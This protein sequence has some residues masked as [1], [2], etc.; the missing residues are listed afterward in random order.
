M[1]A[2]STIASGG[3]RIWVPTRLG[4]RCRKRGPQRLRHLV[5]ETDLN[6]AGSHHRWRDTPVSAVTMSAVIILK[7]PE[8]MAVRGRNAGPRGLRCPTA[9]PGPWVR[10]A[11]CSDGIGCG[12]SSCS[13]GRFSGGKFLEQSWFVERVSLMPT[14]IGGDSVHGAGVLHADI[15]LRELGAAD[16][17]G[18]GAAFGAVT[19]VGPW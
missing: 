7:D 17:S 18:A 19:Q 13:C 15:L 6:R 3:T 14:L 1:S 16:L 8:P 2:T 10:S 4:R 12:E 9:W 5:L 11:G